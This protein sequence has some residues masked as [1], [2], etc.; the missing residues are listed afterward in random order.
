[1]QFSSTS[2]DMLSRLLKNAL[3][4]RIRFSQTFQ[5]FNLNYTRFELKKSKLQTNQFWQIPSILRFHSNTNNRRDREFHNT[6]I[7]SILVGCNCS[8]FN[9]VLINTNKS[10]NISCRDIFN[11]FNI[12]SHH[13][14]CTKN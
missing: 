13:E 3:H 1:M 9:E 14:N 10:S 6:Q 2:N 12:T 8:T 11:W 5:T 4:H 7:V